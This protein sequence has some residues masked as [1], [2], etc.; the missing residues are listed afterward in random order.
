MISPVAEGI[1]PENATSIYVKTYENPGNS[2]GQKSG[3]IGTGSM[4]LPPELVELAN[5]LVSL[6]QDQQQAILQL[7]KNLSTGQNNPA[8]QNPPDGMVI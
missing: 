8:G 1:E 6:P 3:Q 7:A 5:L 4:T 2:G